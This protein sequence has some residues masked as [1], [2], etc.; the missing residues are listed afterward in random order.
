M[1]GRKAL[2]L[3]CFLS[4]SSVCAAAYADGCDDLASNPKWT[5]G[6]SD[7]KRYTADKKYD[8]AL[9]VARSLYKTCPKSPVLN[10]YIGVSLKGN[11]D[12]VKATQYFQKASDLTREMSVS[13]ETARLIYYARYESEYPDRAQEAIDAREAEFAALEAE[14]EKL[15]QLINSAQ[16]EQIEY[17]YASQA[18]TAPEKVR[19]SQIMWVGISTGIAGAAMTAIGATLFATQDNTVGGKGRKISPVYLTGWTMFGAGLGLLI[20][21]GATA[22]IAG[23]RFAHV[24]DYVDLS[25]SIAPNYAALSVTF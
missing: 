4:F 25:V 21:G 12:T 22:G 8:K 6:I 7:I 24:D 20:A 18:G 16:I 15:R 5:S 11:G 10:Y 2:G 19:Y 3:A 13:P 9:G 14:N 23:Y 17:K 1:N